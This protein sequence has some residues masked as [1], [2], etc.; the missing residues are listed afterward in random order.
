MMYNWQVYA[1]DDD[2][3]V[4]FVDPMEIQTGFRPSTIDQAQFPNLKSWLMEHYW[5]QNTEA[6][7]SAQLDGTW[8]TEGAG[9]WDGCEPYH[10]NN[11]YKSSPVT[12]F[13]DG[14]VGTFEVAQANS[15]S[16]VVGKANGLFANGAGGLWHSDTSDA[17]EGYFISGR[18][19][20]VTWSGHS[21]T[22]NGI[23]GRDVL[24]K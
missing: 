20:W 15:D 2:N 16:I 1:W 22:T 6:E 3:D 8:F 11:S 19:D 14:H 23:K 12:A 9:C 10:Y 21:H 5:L 17:A 7:C 13:A 24:G 4:T 18:T